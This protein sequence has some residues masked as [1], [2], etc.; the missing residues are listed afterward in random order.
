MVVN[1]FENPEIL[2]LAVFGAPSLVQILKILKILKIAAFGAPWL[3]TT[4]KSVQILRI[5]LFGNS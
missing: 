5:K 4:L 1:N 3:W 2:K